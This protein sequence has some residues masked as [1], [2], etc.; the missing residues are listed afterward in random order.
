MRLARDFPGTPVVK[1]PCFHCK[2]HISML[3]SMGGKKVGPL[4]AVLKHTHGIKHNLAK[5]PHNN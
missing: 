1:T 5:N 3:H 2:G 4:S